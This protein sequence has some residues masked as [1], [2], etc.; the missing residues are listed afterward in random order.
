MKSFQEVTPAIQACLI[1]AEK[2]IEAAKA[3]SKPGS[4]HIAYHLAA[5]ALEEIGKSSMVFMSA[6]NPQ[7]L[8]EG[9]QV[10]PIVSV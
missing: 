10:G 7:Q 4:Y 2:L 1:N 9:E 5:L 3:T 6:L 8:E